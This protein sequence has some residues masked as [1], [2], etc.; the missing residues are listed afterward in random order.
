MITTTKRFPTLLG[1]V[2][3]VTPTLSTSVRFTVYATRKQVPELDVT[4][5]V[6]SPQ[7]SKMDDV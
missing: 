5:S 4:G 1:L 3:Y 7:V 6:V 2:G